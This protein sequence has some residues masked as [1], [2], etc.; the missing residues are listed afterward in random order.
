MGE[1]I[2]YRRFR[3]AKK[4]KRHKA[5]LMDARSVTKRLRRM[6]YNDDIFYELDAMGIPP[7]EWEDHLGVAGSERWKDLEAWING[8]DDKCK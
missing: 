6:G 5:L 4:S 2:T 8:G 1:L 7:S 3:L